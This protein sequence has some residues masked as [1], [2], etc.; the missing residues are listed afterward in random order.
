MHVDC[1]F[2]SD[3]MKMCKS[4]PFGDNDWIDKDDEKYKDVGIALFNKVSKRIAVM[5]RQLGIDVETI[6]T[7]DLH[8]QTL[9]FP[10]V[11]SKVDHQFTGESLLYWVSKYL[12]E[13]N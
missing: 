7:E 13:I 5:F 2:C 8:T 3:K 4:C 1:Y 6:K 11:K 9:V 10:K 12:E